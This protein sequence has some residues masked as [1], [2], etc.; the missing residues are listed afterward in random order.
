MRSTPMHASPMRPPLRETDT[1]PPPRCCKSCSEEDKAPAR[2]CW[3]ALS[4][5]GSNPVRRKEV[6]VIFAEAAFLEEPTEDPGRADTRPHL[7]HDARLPPFTRT[8]P[9]TQQ[10][11]SLTSKQY[12]TEHSLVVSRERGSF[13][14]ANSTSSRLKQPHARHSGIPE[15]SHTRFLQGPDGDLSNPTVRRLRLCKVR[16]HAVQR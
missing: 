10:H 16:C 11:E 5:R 1:C 2:Y 9:N 7:T 15:L 4:G 14:A 6:K 3:A 12:T 13:T 8:V